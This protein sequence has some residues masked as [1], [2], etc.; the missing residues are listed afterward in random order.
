MIKLSKRLA[1]AASLLEGTGCVLDVGT[2]HGYLPVWLAQRGTAARI[3]AS[4]LRKG[5]LFRAMQS[6]EEYGVAEKIEFFLSDGLRSI[7]SGFDEIVAAGMGGETV[8]SILEPAPWTKNVRLILQPQSKQEELCAWLMEHGYRP[9]DAL[10]AE[11]GGKLYTILAVTGGAAE[12]T[13]FETFFLRPLFERRDGLFPR[14]TEGLMARERLAIRGLEAGESPDEKR[15][16]LLRERLR[17]LEAWREKWLKT[18]DSYAD[19]ER[20]L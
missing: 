11:E 7:D 18:E 2:D 8:I 3:A 4:D 20:C 12:G 19:G 14:Y 6:A 5:P 15:L 9:L 10:L 16:A 1:A 17:L 13:P